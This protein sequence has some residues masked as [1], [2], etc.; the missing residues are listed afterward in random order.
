MNRQVKP[1]EAF[2]ADVALAVEAPAEAADQIDDRIEQA[3][4]PPERRQH[5]D[6]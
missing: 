2:R 3:D 1:S 4:R 6:E 5:V